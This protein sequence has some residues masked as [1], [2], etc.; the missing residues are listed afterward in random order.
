[1]A[2]FGCDNAASFCLRPR[3]LSC[4]KCFFSSLPQSNMMICS[5]AGCR[6]HSKAVAILDTDKPLVLGTSSGGF[7]G[8]GSN[9]AAGRKLGVFDIGRH[10]D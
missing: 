6:G 4:N 2:S 8:L 7:D 5:L 1:M 3:L 10:C 9:R